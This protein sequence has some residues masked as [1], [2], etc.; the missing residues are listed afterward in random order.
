MIMN[1]EFEDNEGNKADGCPE[2]KKNPELSLVPLKNGR[3]TTML[4]GVKETHECLQS[5]EDEDEENTGGG[6]KLYNL[7][8]RDFQK[9]L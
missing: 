9:H 8:M 3:V 5:V 4:E 2:C 6:Y 7:N 1:G